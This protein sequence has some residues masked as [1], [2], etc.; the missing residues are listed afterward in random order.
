MYTVQHIQYIIGE[1]NVICPHCAALRFCGESFNYRHNGK[2]TLPNLHEYR[3]ELIV[4]TF[5]AKFI[6]M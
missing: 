5:M 1:M 2:V 4:F 3:P 6:T